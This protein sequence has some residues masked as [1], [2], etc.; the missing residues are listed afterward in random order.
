MTTYI[1]TPTE[2]DGNTVGY[3]FTTEGELWDY[4]TETLAY[5]YGMD[6]ATI[7]GTVVL[8]H[9]YGPGGRNMCDGHVIGKVVAQ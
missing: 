5:E 7:E 6:V 2:P 9:C 3:T 1:L 8:G 4:I